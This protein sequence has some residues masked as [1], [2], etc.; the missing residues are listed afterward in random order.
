MKLDNDKIIYGNQCK[1]KKGPNSK[2]CFIHQS[3]L[4][5]GDYFEE[6]NIM[7]K[8]HFEKNSNFDK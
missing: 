4:S 2:Y 5:H 3:K 6:P 7:I 8:E 1:K